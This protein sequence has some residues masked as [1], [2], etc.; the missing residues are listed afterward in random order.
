[1]QTESLQSDL[2]LEGGVAGRRLQFWASPKGNYF[3]DI[4]AHGF[5]YEIMPSLNWA[6]WWKARVRAPADMKRSVLPTPARKW[7]LANIRKPDGSSDF[8]EELDNRIFP[9][10]CVRDA[11]LWLEA[12]ARELAAKVG[13]DG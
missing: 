2:P 1:M 12:R 9:L 11:K 4:D 3:V 7:Y 10:E 5:V 8:D 13:R 6:G